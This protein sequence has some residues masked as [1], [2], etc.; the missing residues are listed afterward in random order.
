MDKNEKLL[1]MIMDFNK[2]VRFAA[3]CNDQGEILWNSQREGVK[4]IVPLDETKKAIKRTIDA[5][6]EN[7]KI[8]NQV[9]S[10]LYSIASYEKIK[11]VSIPLGRGHVLFLSIDNTAKKSSKTKNYGNIA[12]M[13]HILS[14]VDFIKSQK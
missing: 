14:I 13:G 8:S 7:S 4:N 11:R 9:G 12:D 6:E 2:S 5:W 1:N 3:I 10:G